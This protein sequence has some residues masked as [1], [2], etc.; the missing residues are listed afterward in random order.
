MAEKLAHEQEDTVRWGVRWQ[1]L[2]SWTSV[3]KGTANFPTAQTHAASGR[4][5]NEW[6]NVFLYMCFEGPVVP[7]S[8]G[9]FC[10]RFATLVKWS[11]AIPNQ[12]ESPALKEMTCP[13]ANSSESLSWKLTEGNL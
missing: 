13:G 1:K 2:A 11:T 10:S 6:M 4:K 8:A 3:V 5:Q 7:G 12:V 9:Q